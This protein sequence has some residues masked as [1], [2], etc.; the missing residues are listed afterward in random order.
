MQ[1]VIDANLFNVADVAKELEVSKAA[2]YKWI[3]ND[4]I[5]TIVFCGVTFITKEEV[6]RKRGSK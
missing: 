2:V 5:D 3:R 6:E 4:T 1:T